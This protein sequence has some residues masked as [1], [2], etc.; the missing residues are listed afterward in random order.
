M[1]EYDV[2]FSLA[3]NMKK[4]RKVQ[5]ISQERLAEKAGCSWQTINAIECSVRFPSP[6]ML[7][8]IAN[9]LEIKLYRLFEV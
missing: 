3:D 4:Y 6:K 9:A 8:K 5:H 1:T 7:A 2:C